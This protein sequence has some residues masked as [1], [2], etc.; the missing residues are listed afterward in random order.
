MHQN[1]KLYYNFD[2]PLIRSFQFSGYLSF[3]KADKEQPSGYQRVIDISVDGGFP[4]RVTYAIRAVLKRVSLMRML[5]EM[6]KLIGK[7][8]HVALE[9]ISNSLRYV[10][11]L[12]SQPLRILPA[13]VV[14]ELPSCGSEGLEQRSSF[15]R[16]LRDMNFVETCN[17]YLRD[18]KELENTWSVITE[19]LVTLTKWEA[20]ITY[21]CEVSRHSTMLVKTLLHFDEENYRINYTA[22]CLEV[23]V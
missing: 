19:I 13:K 20:G 11:H 4:T 16:M 18:V 1:S 23:C 3:I 22:H 10:D 7:E 17:E 21:L 15:V 12:F 9:E 2:F 6:P 8:M 5:N 14:V